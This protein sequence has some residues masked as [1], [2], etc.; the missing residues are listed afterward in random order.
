MVAHTVREARTWLGHLVDNAPV[1]EV[2]REESLRRVDKLRDEY[3]DDKL[4]GAN[5]AKTRLL[6]IDEV[7]EAL[8]WSKADFNPEEATPRTGFTDYM[9]REGDVARLI[10]EAKRYDQTF[11]SPASTL[12]KSDYSVGYLRRSF[13]PAL[14]EVI[15]QAERYAQE[16]QVPF[17]VVTNGQEWALLQLVPTPG[18]SLNELRCVYFG[19]LLG[20]HFV[21]ELFWD[22][23]SKQAVA[24]GAL[25]DYFSQLNQKEAEFSKTPKAELGDLHWAAPPASPSLLREFYD[26]FFDEIVDPG[27]RRMLEQC[28]VSD[29]RLDQYKGELTRALKD[30]AP[31]YIRDAQDISP[32]DLDALAPKATGD[33]K[34]RVVIVTGSVGCGKTTFVTKA[35]VEA[36]QEKN[37]P[38]YFLYVDL[39]DEVG[40]A[41]AEF[42]AGVWKKLRAEWCRIRQD[43]ADYGLLT[44]VFAQQVRELRTG[45]KSR[46]FEQDGDEYRKAEADLLER[47]SSDAEGFIAG[48]WRHCHRLGHAVSVVFDNGDRASEDYQR[49]VYAFA[50]RLARETGAT[51][52][53]TMREATFFQGQ[54]RFLDVR[55]SDIVLHLSAPDL[56]RLLSK[57]IKYVESEL[58]NDHRTARWRRSYEWAEFKTSME[59][60]AS[61]LKET[62]L[63]NGSR[64][65]LELLAAISWHDIRQFLMLVRRLHV[66]LGGSGS[67]W[68]FEPAL[69]ALMVAGANPEHMLP[70]VPNVFDPPFQN[71]DCY[72]LKLRILELLQH[73]LP[74]AERRRGK[75]LPFILRVTRMYG[76]QERWTRKAV[77]DLV[78]DRVLECIQAPAAIEYSRGYEVDDAHTFRVSPLA[79]LLVDGLATNRGYLA[80]CGNS[81]PFHVSNWLGEYVDVLKAANVTE[82]LT[83]EAVRKLTSGGAAAVVGSYL[84][85]RL[86][87]ETPASDVTRHIPEAQTIEQRVTALLGSWQRVTHDVDEKPPVD[88]AQLHLK[89]EQQS[90]EPATTSPAASAPASRKAPTAALKAAASSVRVVGSTLGPLIFAALA[91]LVEG[92]T[93]ATTGAEITR[94]INMYLVDDHNRKEPTNVSRAL[95]HPVLRAQPWL[96][97]AIDPTSGH[98]R[99]ALKPGWVEHWEEL[100]GIPYSRSLV[101]SEPPPP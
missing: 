80:L 20:E 69:A 41:T 11:K 54:G 13:G 35:L 100:F 36:R 2:D 55:S 88:T 60:Y 39:I 92:G 3:R 7:L 62:F 25:E 97:V 18:A 73:A 32:S 57:R 21:F 42:D 4:A 83:T 63:V 49:H 85:D 96:A 101:D 91:V 89:F 71:Y 68:D 23:L 38:N 86:T 94:T 33:Q 37:A 87:V 65:L 95:R 72:F 59:Q 93:S 27:R 56:V 64:A 44:Q 43:A 28:F 24:E 1:T 82:G 77:R 99:Y 34:G 5:E 46:L 6:V 40:E 84:V 51:V 31:A 53:I 47:L 58:E 78:R 79:V 52:I 30:S 14:T 66:T 12:R 50:H 74:P 48:S 22:L 70:V 19:N 90:E 45:A 10:V 8:G 15:E 16:T 26:L 98:P 61:T 81:M 67:T 76:Y 17:A 9:L 75:G 29:S